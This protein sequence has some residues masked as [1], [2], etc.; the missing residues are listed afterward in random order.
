MRRAP[1]I[2]TAVAAIATVAPSTMT[3]ADG[4]AA[5]GSVT[6][7]VTAGD[8]GQPISH[9]CA[10]ASRGATVKATD[11]HPHDGVYHLNALAPAGYDIGFTTF[12]ELLRSGSY[13][14]RW[15][16]GGP[17]RST[18][19]PV[20]VNAGSETSGIDATL[21]P[22]GRIMGK[23]TDARTGQPLGKA[24]ESCFFVKAVTPVAVPVGYDNAKGLMSAE[25]SAAFQRGR[26]VLGGLPTGTYL[27]YYDNAYLNGPYFP[28]WY[29]GAKT[30]AHA[31]RIHVTIGKTVS[32]INAHMARSGQIVGKVVDARTGKPLDSSNFYV[33][34]FNLHDK[35]VSPDYWVGSSGVFHLPQLTTG[36][37]RVQ[38]T[39]DPYG[40]QDLWFDGAGSFRSATDVHVTTGK[41][42]KLPTIQLRRHGH[43]SAGAHSRPDRA[44][45]SS[46]PRSR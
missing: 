9:F 45:M 41:N 30:K 16:G 10:V 22:G 33:V 36:T 40:Y 42:T 17:D 4:T 7:T 21:E 38:I 18:A 37:Y 8:T 11:C 35:A 39:G 13:A 14:P 31:K 29:D 20:T 28:Q 26:Y 25:C 23:A 19:T 3:R 15:Y 27:I 6:G 43:A 24:A 32:G 34:A 44:R 2:F 5:T 1:L 12:T 46:Y